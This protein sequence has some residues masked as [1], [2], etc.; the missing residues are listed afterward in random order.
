M[1]AAAV[2]I[3]LSGY[4]FLKKFATGELPLEP[5]LVLMNASRAEVEPGRVALTAQPLD[6]HCTVAG[7]VHGGYS[8]TLLESAMFGA[9]LSQMPQGATHTSLDRH[10][11]NVRA[12]TTQV[13]PIRIEGRVLHLGARIATAEGQVRDAQGRL[14]AHGTLTCIVFHSGQNFN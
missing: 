8:S 9:I 13:G 3:G 4:D 5:M 11:H 7:L 6:C 2:S 10:V 12:I 14:Y 1:V